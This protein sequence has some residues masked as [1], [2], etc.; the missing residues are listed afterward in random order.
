MPP[1][2]VG[3]QRRRRRQAP[4]GPA[5]PAAAR[6]VP[7]SRP[8]VRRRRTRTEPS[9]TAGGERGDGRAPG[10]QVEAPGSRSDAGCVAEVEGRRAAG[11]Q[12]RVA[13]AGVLRLPGPGRLR[14]HRRR[15][16]AESGRPRP[17]GS[18]SRPGPARRRSARPA[19]TSGARP[20]RAWSSRPWIVD[21][22]PE[23]WLTVPSAATPSKVTPVAGSYAGC[24]DA[25]A[26]KNH[27]ATIPASW[28]AAAAGR[29]QRL[30]AGVHAVGDLG[31]VDAR[32]EPA[33]VRPAGGQQPRV[34]GERVAC[35]GPARGA[36]AGDGGRATPAPPASASPRRASGRAGQRP[37]QHA[38]ER[39][40]CGRR[41]RTSRRCRR[42]AASS[43]VA[44]RRGRRRARRRPARARLR[45]RRRR[46][47][48]SARPASCWPSMSRYVAVGVEHLPVD[49]AGREV[50]ALRQ[51]AREGGVGCARRRRTPPPA[52]RPC[53]P[54]S[55]TR[56][57][58][59]GP[60][61]RPARRSG[62]GCRRAAS[63]ARRCRGAR[64]SWSAGRSRPRSIS[65][66]ARRLEARAGL[67]PVAQVDDGRA[68]HVVGVERALAVGVGGRRR[69]SPPPTRS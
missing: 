43:R 48:R 17:G 61:A 33:V 67:L 37:R 18:W 66:A 54:A 46:R 60:A 26:P 19:S 25:L 15:A 44:R 69:R 4:S 27:A 23:L 28:S 68:G 32:R 39:P 53:G 7:A 41:R 35:G 24:P 3:G 6:P 31:A 10:L 22:A 1:V 55:T 30:D 5:S 42:S 62:S 52:P 8:A 16:A 59:T 13:G 9:G 57:C 20:G 56:R 11:R 2:V 38:A 49:R 21:S 65:Y 47:R 51:E 58:P 29:E 40:A 63:R 50:E 36:V 64:R 14:R 45:R 12:G 34:E